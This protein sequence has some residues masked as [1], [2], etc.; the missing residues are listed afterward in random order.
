MGGGGGR[1]GVKRA[2]TGARER[3]E[4]PQLPQTLIFHLFKDVR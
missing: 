1:E 4:L 3:G 2:Y